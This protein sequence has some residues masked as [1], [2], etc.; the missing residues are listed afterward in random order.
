MKYLL[1]LLVILP[2][3]ALAQTTHTYL[4]GKYKLKGTTYTQ[5]VFFE[6]KEVQGKDNCEKERIYGRG[7]SWRYYNHMVN[8]TRGFSA[9]VNYFC[10][11]TAINFGV[12]NDY[13]EYE[14]I[15]LIDIRTNNPVVTETNTYSN[16]LREMRKEQAK[17]NHNYFC[18]RSN[19]KILSQN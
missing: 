15:Y 10:I 9:N 2:L 17:E 13:A 4:L 16:C 6:E 14:H 18:A 12:W 5:V 7:G 8:R 1:M 11:E 3:N 19:Q